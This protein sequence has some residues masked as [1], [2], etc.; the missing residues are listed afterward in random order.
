[1]NNNYLGRFTWIQGYLIGRRKGEKRK[2]LA[3]K[4]N[5]M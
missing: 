1:M 3:D 5:I 2:E 4:W